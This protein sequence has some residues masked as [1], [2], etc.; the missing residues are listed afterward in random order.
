MSG[1][2]TGVYHTPVLAGVVARLAQGARRAVDCTVGGGGHSALILAGGAELLAIDRDPEAIAHARE[3]LS[4]ERARL[5]TG[6]FASPEVMSVIRAFHPDFVLMDLGVSARQLEEDR[7]GFSFRPGVPLDMRMNPFEHSTPTG[8]DLLNS[9]SEDDLARLF[10]ENA[11]ERR[12]R[13]LARA[14]V[15]RRKRRPFALSDDLVGAIREALGPGTGPRDFAR[16]FQ[17][18]RMAVNREREELEGALPQLLEAMAPGGMMVAISYHS[19][20]DR[21]VKRYFNEWSRSCICPPG[22]PVCRCT[23]IARGVLLTRRPIRPDPE[24]V[25]ANP[26]ARSAKLRAFRKSDAR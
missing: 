19:G 17:A 6:R 21:I 14:I 18:L 2:S 23:G 11:D 10:R 7:R 12:A 25:A 13:R 20:E 4:G 1:G 3:L 22:Q 15:K 16:I 9:W 24:E 26:R 8:A 5:L